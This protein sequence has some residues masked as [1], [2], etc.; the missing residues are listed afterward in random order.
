[1]DV[2]DVRR[3]LSVSIGEFTHCYSRRYFAV[4]LTSDMGLSGIHSFTVSGD[5]LLQWGAFPHSLGLVVDLFSGCSIAVSVAGIS[6]TV[7]G[8]SLSLCDQ[9]VI[10]LI[11]IH[12]LEGSGDSCYNW[13]SC[14]NNFCNQL[15]IH[16]VYAL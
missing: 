14:H 4:F 3:F 8:F 10:Y 16:L 2:C 12:S 1:M 9:E 13:E 11:D 5:F 15:W 6:V 7:S